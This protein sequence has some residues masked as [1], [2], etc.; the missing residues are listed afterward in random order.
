M[1]GFKSKDIICTE[2]NDFKSGKL[3]KN[4]FMRHKLWPRIMASD[5][6]Q[7]KQVS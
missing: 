7:R 1:I 5:Y 3:Y 4:N 2:I 6:I